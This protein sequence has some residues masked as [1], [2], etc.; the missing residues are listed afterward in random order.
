MVIHVRPNLSARRID[1][2]ECAALDETFDNL[3]VH[4]SCINPVAEIRQRLKRTGSF[5]NRNNI[6]DGNLTDIF[7]RGHPEAD[8][9]LIHRETH[10]AFVHI[11]RQHFNL[12]VPALVDEELN[13]IGVRQFVRQQCG[14][15]L[16]LE[17]RL[18][19]SRL[20]GDDSVGGA[21]GFVK[22]IAGKL[23]QR[24]K[25]LFGFCLR[26]FVRVRATFDKGDALF[27]HF[28]RL[29]L[30]HRPAQQIGTT[31]CITG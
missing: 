29:F 31:K 19:I 5:P 1:H 2:I 14:H 6:L 7:N 3:P 13:F 8:S 26:N 11:R 21:V 4:N 9:A 27:F 23:R 28:F 30:T 20:V 17:V 16:D 24:V 25:N 15:E 10:T 18:Q 12:H 22:T